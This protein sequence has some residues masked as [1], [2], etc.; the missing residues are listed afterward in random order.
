MEKEMLDLL[1]DMLN[2]ENELIAEHN[3]NMY[4]ISLNDLKDNNKEYIYINTNSE[5]VFYFNESNDIINKIKNLDL[6][7]KEQKKGKDI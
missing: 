2:E 4:Y 5:K 6:D 1:L 3:G 7:F